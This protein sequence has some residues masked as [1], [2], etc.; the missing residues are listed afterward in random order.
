[1]EVF[2]MSSISE[3]VNSILC[4]L[5][6]RTGKEVTLSKPSNE[7]PKLDRHF[8]VCDTIE[9]ACNYINSGMDNCEKDINT[10]IENCIRYKGFHGGGDDK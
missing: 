6:S 5:S 10:A 7:R 1:M 3:S 8:E 2:Y 9:E 4:S